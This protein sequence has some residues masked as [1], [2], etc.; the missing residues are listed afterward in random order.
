MS[1]NVQSTLGGQPL[2]IHENGTQP[3]ANGLS[4]W[5][6]RL[7]NSYSPEAFDGPDLPLKCVGLAILAAETAETIAKRSLNPQQQAMI[8]SQR[9]QIFIRSQNTPFSQRCNLAVRSPTYVS[10]AATSTQ[11][12]LDPLSTF[13]PM[14]T[15]SSAPTKLSQNV[16]T[17]ETSYLSLPPS[18]AITSNPSFLPILTS[19]IMPSAQPKNLFTSLTPSL[20]PFQPISTPSNMPSIPSQYLF[21]SQNPYLRPHPS[22]GSALSPSFQ[23]ILTP[24]SM[25][26]AQPQNLLKRK[27]E[28][29]YATPS[30]ISKKPITEPLPTKQPLEFLAEELRY[31]LVSNRLTSD[32]KKELIILIV[33]RENL[34]YSELVELQSKLETRVV[35]QGGKKT[36]KELFLEIRATP[37][38][39]QL[40]P[41]SAEKKERRILEL[42]NKLSD[43][44]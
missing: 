10:F 6:S 34:L 40:Y 32:E 18:D 14:I 17:F 11:A 44:D 25:P 24:S 20:N 5:L 1:Y 27:R 13:Q 16:F 33:S 42:K 12:P 15:S 43:S 31:Y 29:S 28:E 26:G 19:S 9:Q 23:P 30:T 22:D 38:F 2:K 35:F 4:Q 3:Q 37:A 41:E 7:V 21:T 39:C 36:M 8:S